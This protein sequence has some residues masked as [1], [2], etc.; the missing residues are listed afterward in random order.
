[1]IVTLDLEHGD[2]AL[3][4]V[5]HARVLA[6]PLHDARA[7]GGQAAQ[8]A[9]ARFV[10]AMLRPHDRE[11]PELRERRAPAEDLA[12]QRDLVLRESVLA[13]QLVGDFRVAHL[14][15]RRAT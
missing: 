4:H 1:M 5:D 15:S 11:D 3:A 10:R 6:G 9:L 2:P 14:R 7:G 8:V 13:G 12:Y